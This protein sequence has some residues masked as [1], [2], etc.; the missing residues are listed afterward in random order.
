M[1]YIYALLL[2]T[3]FLHADLFPEFRT[4]PEARHMWRTHFPANLIFD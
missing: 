2:Q 4:G 1:I 3:E